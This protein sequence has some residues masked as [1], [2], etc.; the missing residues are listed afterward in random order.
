MVV[1]ARFGGI[2]ADRWIYRLKENDS[3]HMLYFYFNMHYLMQT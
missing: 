1:T 3:Q 2:A